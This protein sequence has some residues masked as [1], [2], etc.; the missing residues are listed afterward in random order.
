MKVF[1]ERDNIVL[2][3]FN[4]T[5]AKNLFELVDQNRQY[6]EKWLSWVEK[7]K[8]VKDIEDFIKKESEKFGKGEGICLGIWCDKELAGVIS[9][10]FINKMNKSGNIGY[11][12]DEKHQG[13]GIITNACR[14][15]ID[16]GFK[17]LKLHRVDIS[18]AMGNERS[19][20]VIKR[21]GFVHEGH[22]R[23]SELIQAGFADQEYYGLLADEW[24]KQ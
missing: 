20:G 19:A 16:Y 1:I 15:L 3:Q 13:K 24:G 2:K 18:H 10:N 11:W 21:L 5:E 7:T 9:F 6:L 12:L 14:L 4:L 23:K 17:T 22:F 8:S